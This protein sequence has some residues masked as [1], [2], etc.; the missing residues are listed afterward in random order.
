M[1]P[2]VSAAA[3]VRV[4]V[5]IPIASKAAINIVET[6]MRCIEAISGRA[7]VRETP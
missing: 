7:S 3:S 2:G 6:L 1:F 4:A 5:D